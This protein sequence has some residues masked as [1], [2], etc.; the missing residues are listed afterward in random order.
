M[1]W[2]GM[3]WYGMVWYGM[4][5]YGMVWCGGAVYLCTKILHN[6]NMV[7]RILNSNNRKINEK[8]TLNHRVGTGN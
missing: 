7:L 3:V 2:Y 1:V 4:V 8:Q 5:W 6:I